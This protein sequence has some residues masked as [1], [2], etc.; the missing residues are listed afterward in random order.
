MREFKNN[1][2]LETLTRDNGNFTVFVKDDD[3]N[4]YIGSSFD[5]C[6]TFAN[7][8]ESCRV[9]PCSDEQGDFYQLFPDQIV[10]SYME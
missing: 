10:A 5:L 8:Q 7:G 6:M 1:T 3:G 2:E 9:F 4:I